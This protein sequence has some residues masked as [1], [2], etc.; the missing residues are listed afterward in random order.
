MARFGVPENHEFPGTLIFLVFV[1]SQA[2]SPRRLFHNFADLALSIV[3]IY[4]FVCLSHC[5]ETT[6][7]LRVQLIRDMVYLDDSKVQSVCFV[8]MGENLNLRCMNI[9]KLKFNAS[10]SH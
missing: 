2:S 10:I 3:V 5:H 9:L 6:L 8:F 4:R 7:L 1:A